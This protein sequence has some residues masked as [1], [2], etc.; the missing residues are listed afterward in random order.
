MEWIAVK[1]IYHF[2]VNSNGINVFEE[3]VVVFE[4]NNSDE[5]HEKAVVEAELYA[6][7]NDFILHPE[8]VGYRQDGEPLIDGYEVWSELF[9][10]NLS[11]DQ[12]YK[13][14]YEKY[15]YHSENA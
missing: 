15:L 3:R 2:G 10:A 7:E 14:R 13:E 6:N 11:L 5:A 12:F 4:A 8:Q 9:E 1:S